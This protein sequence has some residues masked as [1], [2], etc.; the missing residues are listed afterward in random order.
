MRLAPSLPSPD[1][2]TGIAPRLLAA[3]LGS[4]LLCFSLMAALQTLL[5]ASLRPALTLLP[6]FICI[7][8]I[9]WAFAARD[10]WQA[11]MMLLIPVTL[12]AA[13][14]LLPA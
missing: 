11:W 4:Y 1:I 10:I 13:I 12:C 5:P 8:T 9:F 3:T 2:H 6:F 7:A 14:V